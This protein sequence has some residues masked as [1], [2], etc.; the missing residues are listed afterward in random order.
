MKETIKYEVKRLAP[1][2][3]LKSVEAFGGQFGV[4]TPNHITY[5]VFVNGELV[6]DGL[7]F[8]FFPR[9]STALKEMEH[10]RLKTVKQCTCLGICKGKDGLAPGWMC[11][12]ENL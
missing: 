1:E 12:N 3:V 9:K 11:A 10:L 6:K 7:G 4:K 2:T 5:G 8:Y